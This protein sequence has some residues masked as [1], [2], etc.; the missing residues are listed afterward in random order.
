MLPT[1][2]LFQKPLPPFGR[3]SACIQ[4]ID[5]AT[6][7][8]CPSEFEQHAVRVVRPLRSLRA[9][10]HTRRTP[11]DGE[12]QQACTAL[13]AFTPTRLLMKVSMSLLLVS[14]DQAGTIAAAFSRPM[15]SWA[16]TKGIA[17]A[18]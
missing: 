16:A 14:R 18:T 2:E 13:S 11:L 10:D 17:A 12:P 3:Y 4:V 5:K 15:E 7:E 1:V 9:N 6:S 8:F